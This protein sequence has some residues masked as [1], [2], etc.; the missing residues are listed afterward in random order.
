METPSH[1]VEKIS[2]HVGKTCPY[3]R[4]PIKPTSETVICS[5]CGQPHH[6]ECWKESGKCTSY[7][8]MGKPMNEQGKFVAGLENKADLIRCIFCS[9]QIDRGVPVCPFCDS[10]QPFTAKGKKAFRNIPSASYGKRVVAT[11]IDASPWF[12]SVAMLIVAIFMGVDEK[13]EAA[14][15]IGILSFFLFLFALFYFLFRDSMGKGQSIGKRLMNLQV[16][17]EVSLAPCKV[18]QS[19]TRNVVLIAMNVLYMMGM[20][21]ESFAILLTPEGRR[22]GDRAAKTMVVD[23]DAIAIDFLKDMDRWEELT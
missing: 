14:L 3:C 7:G 8:C 20:V 11:F 1:S 9:E 18:S 15:I 2:A 23:R 5:G 10:L 21:V 12:V 19:V 6:R 13:A 16:L 22:L 4:F 17:D